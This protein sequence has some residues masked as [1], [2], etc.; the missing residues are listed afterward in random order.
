MPNSKS[1]YCVFY[2]HPWTALLLEKIQ[3]I[4]FFNSILI[5]L[6]NQAILSQV[7]V[8]KVNKKRYLTQALLAP[9]PPKKSFMDFL[10]GKK[11]DAF[12]R[13]MQI[14]ADMPAPIILAPRG[15]SALNQIAALQICANQPTLYHQLIVLV[16]YEEAQNFAGLY[17]YVDQFHVL[18]DVADLPTPRLTELTTLLANQSLTKERWGGFHLCNHPHRQVADSQQR[19]HFFESVIADCPLIV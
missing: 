5:E 9:Q 3:D 6:S 16:H 8:P 18:W 17:D 13:A 11:P 10:S 4:N 12:Q 14:T 2:S 19:Y 15:V 1:L 7:I